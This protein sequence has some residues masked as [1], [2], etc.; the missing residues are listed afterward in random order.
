MHNEPSRRRYER[1]RLGGNARMVLDTPSGLQT[2]AGQLID[3]SEGG[4][5][6]LSR[7]YVPVRVP[8]RLRMVVAASEMWLPV[9]VVWVQSGK[10]GW[11][12]GC[13]FD[14]PTD[15]KQRMLRALLWERRKF[16]RQ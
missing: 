2:T 1:V 5:A 3:L 8:G 12:V 4:C 6:V 10:H 9:T 7:S 11:M 14:R 15:E 16:T 13:E